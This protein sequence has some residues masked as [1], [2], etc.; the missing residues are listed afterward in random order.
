MEAIKEEVKSSHQL[1]HLVQLFQ[2]REAIGPWDYKE[3]ILYF[4]NRIY[5][6]PDSTLVPLIVKEMHASTREGYHKTLQRMKSAFYWQGM[7]KFL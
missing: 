4:K 3:G 2:N 7:R 6:L 5:L 1:Q